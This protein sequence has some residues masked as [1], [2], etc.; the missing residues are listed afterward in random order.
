[1]PPRVSPAARSERVK[2]LRS[3]L[4]ELAT[5]PA[6]PILEINREV[7]P[8]HEMSTVVKLLETR[9]NPV[10]L[11]RQVRG[12]ELRVL[13]GLCAARARIARALGQSVHDCADWLLAAMDRPIPSRP[14]ATGPVKEIRHVAGSAT[15]ESLPIGIHSR[16]DGGRYITSGVML[17]RDPATHNV[18]AGIYRTMVLDERRVTVSSPAS[19]D[20]GKIM[21]SC[22]STRE[23]IDFAIVIGHHPALAIA[24][25]AKNP[26]SLDAYGL[27]GALMDQPLEVT[28]AETVDLDVPAF[29][30]IVIEGRILPWLREPEGP[31]G[32]YTYYYGSGQ[33]YVCE[34]SAITHRR[35]AIF[36]DLHP[37]HV[38]HRCLWL[39]P[40]REARLLNSLREAVP[41]VRSVRLPFHGGGLS[42]YVSLEKQH[43]GDATRAL[44]TTLSSDNYI[45]HAFVL[46]SDIDIY[47]D[48]QVLW[49][50]NVRFQGDRDLVVIPNARGS[51]TDPS[52]YSRFDRSKPGGLTTKLGFDLT[53]P[54]DMATPERAD[55]LADEYGDI[56]LRHYV[57]PA[58]LDTSPAEQE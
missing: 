42:A 7:D 56:D 2:D 19:H 29:A 30:E 26:M 45:K 33:G 22:A 21:E 10:I 8:V 57:P 9:G 34:V 5:D 27:T 15:L 48:K 4:A 58:R 49:A 14:V 43:D 31:F 37:T 6:D 40:G 25:Q 35:Q 51:R 1:V 46:D 32:E 23:P 3:F 55:I 24:S 50:F 44:I 13:F 36:V 28:R 17:V 47:D 39:F 11:F 20:L 16:A 54:L 38:E 12:F 18:N 53:F 41:T 52:G